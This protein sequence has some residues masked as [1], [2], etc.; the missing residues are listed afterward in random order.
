MCVVS[1][2]LKMHTLEF[3]CEFM[4]EKN[5][6]NVMYVAKPLVKMHTLQYIRESYWRETI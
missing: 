2:L 3:I 5:H 1:A 4:L 6:I